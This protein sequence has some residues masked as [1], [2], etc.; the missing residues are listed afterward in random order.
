MAW[1]NDAGG[2]NGRKIELTKR[3]T[4]LVEGQQ[5]IAE[6]C[7]EDFM[8]VGG[9]SAA[10]RPD[11]RPR[12]SC[13][14]PQIPGLTA[15]T[16]AIEADLQVQVVPNFPDYLDVS[17]HKLAEDQFP[18]VGDH[19]GV[20]AL[21]A[22]GDEPGRTTTGSEGTTA[23]G[24][25]TVY[26]GDI[27]PPPATVDNWRPYVE[28]M[29]SDGVTILDSYIIGDQL[30]P[31]MAMM[32]DLQW[33]PEVVVGNAGQ[34]SS[35]LTTGN[36]ALDDVPTWVPTYTTPFEMADEN[37]PIQQFLDLMDEA[38][39]GWSDD[40]KALA[41][42]GWSAWLLF[43]Q[44]A[45]ACG[46]D[47]TRDCVME[48]AASTGDWDAG[49]V[50]APVVVTDDVSEPSGPKCIAA[51]R[52]KPDGFEYDE[53]FTQPNEGIFHCDEDACGSPQV[54]EAATWTSS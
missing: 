6:A 18:G 5:R 27:P 51:M 17:I 9:A 45:T 40:P 53:E 42:Q 52:A 8:L 48:K 4:K 49:G 30:V 22:T 33:K 15:D 43:A 23:I 3:D 54:G 19:Y 20:L 35:A 36:D 31:V 21:A 11:R 47:L 26:K 25:T 2:I 7:T 39:P 37:Q 12:V 50:T 1:C 24:F 13:G 28:T 32:N 44:S 10:R 16:A 38:N 14:L 34:Y 41:V 29:K 46:S